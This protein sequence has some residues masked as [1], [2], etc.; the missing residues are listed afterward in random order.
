MLPFVLRKSLTGSL[1]IR[2]GRTGER[3]DTTRSAEVEMYVEWI[4]WS[5]L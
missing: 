3:M 5:Q 1:R 2:G 4:P